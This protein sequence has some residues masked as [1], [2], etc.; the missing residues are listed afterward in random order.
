M[1][2]RRHL[3]RGVHDQEMLRRAMD[4]SLILEKVDDYQYKAVV[5]VRNKGA[6]HHLPTYM[7]PKISLVLFLT[8]D[9]EPSREIGRD[10]IGWRTDV[11]MNEEEFDTRIPAGGLH[12]FEKLFWI[13]RGGRNWNVRLDVIV[14]PAEHYIRTFRYSQENVDLP[15]SSREALER[16]IA[17]AE[18]KRYTATSIS[19]EP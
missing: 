16:A 11:F 17:E 1:E 14:D 10:V 3:W 18:A 19:A 7:V 2:E 4:S 9:S 5:I 8:S 13:P 6:G 15:Q 12:R